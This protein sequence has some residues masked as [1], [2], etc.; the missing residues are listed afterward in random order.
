M[1]TDK[2]YDRNDNDTYVEI[3]SMNPADDVEIHMY[4][5]PKGGVLM[6]GS[7]KIRGNFSV[8]SRLKAA[9]SVLQFPTASETGLVKITDRQLPTFMP[10]SLVSRYNLS[11]ERLTYT[12]KTPVFYDTKVNKFIVLLDK[13][14][15]RD[16]KIAE[17]ALGDKNPH[18]RTY[19]DKK[20]GCL[21]YFGMLFDS[22]DDIVKQ[23]AVN[24]KHENQPFFNFLR[25]YQFYK[26]TLQ[27]G[28]KVIIVQFRSEENK[29][30]HLFG[31]DMS[32]F[33]DK[34]LT[35][36][37]FNIEHAVAVRFGLRYYFCDENGKILQNSAF[38]LDKYLQQKKEDT[39]LNHAL[40]L[41]NF[42]KRVMDKKEV[43]VTAYSE[44]QLAIIE[45]L[46][47]RMYDIQQELCN[48]FQSATNSEAPLDSSILSLPQQNSIQKFLSKD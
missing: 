42:S 14:F 19:K 7:N 33:V 22:M 29:Q 13:R 27:E 6:G 25:A 36:R 34:G 16:I 12:Q 38:H 31:Y 40:T 5:D 46:S 18:Y 9:N 37:S 26:M 35:S 39:A 3:Y 15:L 48:L 11:E 8:E 1:T 30:S 41:A 17:L 20:N 47:K 28:E 45:A 43:F 4:Q 10:M 32:K 24:T 21:D 2:P 23:C 44:E